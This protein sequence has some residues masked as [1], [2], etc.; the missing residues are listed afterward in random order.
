MG[1]AMDTKCLSRYRSAC[2][3]LR[4]QPEAVP[5][6]PESAQ[7]AGPAAA[8]AEKATAAAERAK[9]HARALA[10]ATPPKLRLAYAQAFCAAVLERYWQK[11]QPRCSRVLRALPPSLRQTLAL[12]TEGHAA[13]EALAEA[14]AALDIDSAGYLVGRTY[15]AMLPEDFRS[16]NGVFYTPPPVVGRLLDTATDAG[17]DWATCRA[18]DPA[19][20]GGAFLGPMARRM[21]RSM[22]GA[23]RRIV[24]RNL[25]ARL[26]GYEVD[27]FA[28][29][30]S[31]VFLDATINEEV[32]VS[33]DD[34]FN[35]IEVCN[36]LTRAED[37]PDFD[38]VIGNPPYGRVT[39]EPSLRAQYR[40]SLYGH[41]NLYGLF[42][43]LALRKTKA[44]GVVAYVTPTGFL[45]GEYFKNLR[46]LL[47]QE[48]S[49]IALEFITE[50]EGIFD[51]VQQE[52]LLAVCRRGARGRR[53]RV[54]FV[55]VA[56]G[57]HLSVSNGGEVT[58]PGDAQQ[59]WIVPREPAAEMI[60][61][62]LRTMPTRLADWGYGVSTG[63][64]VWNRFKDRLRHN[65]EKGSV[66]LL[67]AEAVG[68]DGSFAFRAA[69]RNHAPYFAVKG[70]EDDWLLVRSP[71]VLLQ[72]TTAKEQA[73][74]LIAAELPQAFLDA[75]GGAVTVEN[76]LN[77]VVPIVP[78]PSV[79]TVTLATF[80]NSAAADRAFRCISGTVA[81]SA[82]ELESMPLPPPQQMRELSNLLSQP[83][84]RAE[85]ENCCN[86]LYGLK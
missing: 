2:M 30:I 20:G 67:W 86:R 40:R 73:R 84:T 10:E 18:L 28:A 3:A 66:P 38:V 64:L 48:A 14:A 65:P 43:D 9:D 41:A 70:S 85:A 83:H 54:N 37:G 19:C 36:S 68:A 77:M 71:C 60:A 44:E 4:S 74:R 35:P 26:V 47:G 51:D 82:Y 55:E 53:T 8:V 39:L 56:S 7:D 29:W 33:G 13:A 23:D 46:S 58:L 15:A 34:S 16:K 1:R 25:S 75:Q 5:A 63:P 12:R 21:L 62:R 6:T 45:S 61:A 80:L 24:L 11:L 17:I 78:H 42:L 49:P 31:A 22:K 52:T 50:R 72:R 59:P 81:V 69:R 57:R 32:G 76:H 79:D 27:P